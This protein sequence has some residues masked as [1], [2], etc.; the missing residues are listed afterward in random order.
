MNINLY[1]PKILKTYTGNHYMKQFLLSLIATTVSI[2]LTFGTAAVIDHNTKQGE[3]REIVMMVMYDMYNSL[4]SIE[5]ADSVLRESMH[6]QLEIAGDTTKFNTLRYQLTHLIPRID[7][8][9]TTEN[10]V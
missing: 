6:L 4:Q 3:K 5:K 2:A 8:T 7:Y 10:I 9:E 1:T